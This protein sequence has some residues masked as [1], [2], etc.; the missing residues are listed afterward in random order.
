VAAPVEVQTVPKRRKLAEPVMV[1]VEFTFAT[2]IAK[3]GPYSA[4]H[5]ER[6]SAEHFESAKKPW[7]RPFLAELDYQRWRRDRKER[8]QGTERAVLSTTG[9]LLLLQRDAQPTWHEIKGEPNARKRKDRERARDIAIA[10][11]IKIVRTKTFQGKKLTALEQL[12]VNN[13]V[14]AARAR[15]RG[16]LSAPKGGRPKKSPAR[17]QRA[18]AIWK[19]IEIKK[20]KDEREED[21]VLKEV[22]KNLG[23]KIRYVREVYRD[24][25]RGWQ[26]AVNA[27]MFFSEENTNIAKA[28]AE[29]KLRRKEGEIA[30]L[31]NLPPSERSQQ[32]E[33]VAQAMGMR[34]AAL[35]V[36]INQ[37]QR[38]RGL[39][40]LR[41]KSP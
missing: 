36:E 7:T 3:H 34:P 37:V 6:D 31:A 8:K 24:R 4:E 18:V 2:P 35:A 12:R 27:E 29:N 15:K 17:L 10:E 28:R 22:A 5:V 20:P 30:R 23:T 38:R 26:K 19:A 11:L 21:A 32:L 41:R 40:V 9:P 16:R 25:D 39:N 1:P 33:T 13:I 14:K